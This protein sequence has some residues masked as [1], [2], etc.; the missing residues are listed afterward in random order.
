[1]NVPVELKYTKEHEWIRIDGN[2]ATVGIT[3]WAQSELGDIVFV[4]LPDIDSEFKQMSAFGTIE[5]VKAVS[6]LFSPLSGKIVEV[7]STLDD[8]PMEINNDPYG[9]GWM[10]KLE[11]STS[12]E[13]DELL[14]ASAYASLVESL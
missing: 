12:S 3:D 14:D 1:M 10:I 11:L 13:I 6:E 8:A 7:N 9:A 4:E 2:V 5:A